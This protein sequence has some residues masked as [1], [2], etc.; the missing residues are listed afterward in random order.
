MASQG[1][2]IKQAEE[3]ISDVRTLQAGRMAH[4]KLRK[5]SRKGRCGFCV[6]VFLLFIGVV[7]I[8]VIFREVTDKIERQNQ[9]IGELKV[10]KKEIEDLSR[11]KDQRIEHFKK[12]IQDANNRVKQLEAHE[13]KEHQDMEM[14][15]RDK[16]VPGQQYVVN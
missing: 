5:S 4:N 9:T 15:T 2:K 11:Q 8:G 10:V 13:E 1:E 14:Q 3:D 7:A 6:K 12:Q 16:V